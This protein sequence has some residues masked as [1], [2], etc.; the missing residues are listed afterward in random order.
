[1]NKIPFLVPYT[2]VSSAPRW[3]WKPWA[4]AQGL[5]PYDL[6]GLKSSAL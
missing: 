6:L 3:L 2:N 4:N 5:K 1:M